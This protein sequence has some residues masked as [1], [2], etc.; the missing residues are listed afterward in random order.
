MLYPSLKYVLSQYVALLPE[1]ALLT[2]MK[3]HGE[4]ITNPRAPRLLRDKA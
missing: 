4:K 2:S 3:I 1:A